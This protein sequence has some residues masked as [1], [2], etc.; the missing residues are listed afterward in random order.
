MTNYPANN[1]TQDA[2]EANRVQE[3]VLSGSTP[4]EVVLQEDGS[5][6]FPGEG[7]FWEYVDKEARPKPEEQAS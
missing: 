7:P 1:A 6:R 2:P 3:K 5:I 4:L